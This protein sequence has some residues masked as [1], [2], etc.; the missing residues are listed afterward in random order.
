MGHVDKGLVLLCG[1]ALVRHAAGRLQAQV[2]ELMVNANQNLDQ[3]AALGYPLISDHIPGFAGPLAGLHAALS[4]ARHDWVVTV[5][6]DSPFLPLD[7]V[8]RLHAAIQRS[9]ARIAMARTGDQVHPVFCLCHRDLLGSLTEYLASGERKFQR[10]I[11]AQ[12]SVEVPFDDQPGAFENLNTRED[13]AR[14]EGILSTSPCLSEN[15]SNLR[16]H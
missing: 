13:L 14:F 4:A 8:A 11:L 2:S 12:Q 15:A 5:P 7:L 1:Q 10:W 3:Y 6:C 16:Q 9:H